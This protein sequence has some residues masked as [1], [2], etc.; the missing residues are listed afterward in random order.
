MKL[1]LRRTKKAKLPT[2]E[3]P[4]HLLSKLGKIIEGNIIDNIAK[5]RQAS[6]VPLKRNRPATVRQKIREGAT[7]GGKV[8]S[9]VALLK[10]FVRPLGLSWKHSFGRRGKRGASF[11]LVEPATHELKNLVIGVQRK[12]YRGWF[13]LSKDGIAAI[14]ATI[15]NWVKSEFRS[16]AA[17]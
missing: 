8:L 14:K 16:K 11:I 15:A 17:Q 5:Q 6:G 9:L 4:E 13:G 2:L 7:V 10:R 3:L 12:G 1:R